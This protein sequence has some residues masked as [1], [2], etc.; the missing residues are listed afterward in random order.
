MIFN[1]LPEWYYAK[2]YFENLKEHQFHKNINTIDQ[3]Q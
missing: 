3:S 2:K 1:Y